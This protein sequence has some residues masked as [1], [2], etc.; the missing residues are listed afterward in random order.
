MHCGQFYILIS[1]SVSSRKYCPFEQTSFPALRPNFYLAQVFFP[2][3]CARRR[4]ESLQGTFLVSFWFSSDDGAKPRTYP[5]ASYSLVK[6]T[7]QLPLI[8]CTTFSAKLLAVY[9]ES[10]FSLICNYLDHLILYQTPP[11]PPTH[12]HTHFCLNKVGGVHSEADGICSCL[13]L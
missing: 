4:S 9:S 2:R 5:D 8:Y 13:L 6:S 3:V 11:S 10:L 12:T 1:Y 7:Q